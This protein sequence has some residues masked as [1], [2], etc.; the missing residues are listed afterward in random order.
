ML[1][2]GG[3]FVVLRL[4]AWYVLGLKSTG[5]EAEDAWKP[6]AWFVVPVFVV[7]GAVGIFGIIGERNRTK[8]IANL[9]VIDNQTFADS[10]TKYAQLA[11]NGAK[12]TGYVRL[13]AKQ[14]SDGPS[15]CKNKENTDFATVMA[16]LGTGG[17]VMIVGANYSNGGYEEL[18]TKSKDN[19]GKE[20]EV[21]GKLRE[22]PSKSFLE[23]WKAYCG[24]ETLPPP[25]GNRWALEMQQP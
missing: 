11:G 6:V 5:P 12:E 16:D 3:S 13:R 25:T 4:F 10:K 20:I 24:I 21:I 14:I 7:C 22:M 18:L 1:A 9:P 23:A 15:Q 17:E 2:F 8:E 19:K